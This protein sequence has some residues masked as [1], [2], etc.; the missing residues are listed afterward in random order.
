MY[1]TDAKLK[2]QLFVVPPPPQQES[3]FPNNL[4]FFSFSLSLS[5]DFTGRETYKLKS[6]LKESRS[7]FS[8]DF[9]AAQESLGH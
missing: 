3:P 7:L 5:L 2:N 8:H 6:A 4:L 1:H 9:T